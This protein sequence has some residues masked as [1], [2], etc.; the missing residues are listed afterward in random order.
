MKSLFNLVSNIK[1][2]EHRIKEVN[3]RKEIY[4]EKDYEIL[5]NLIENDRP[6]RNKK[7]KKLQEILIEGGLI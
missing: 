2:Q 4:T 6:I 5:M 1:V 3:E 7:L